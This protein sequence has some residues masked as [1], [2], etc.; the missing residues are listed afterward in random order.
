MTGEIP[1]KNGDVLIL[2]KTAGSTHLICPVSNDG[3]Q[4]GTAGYHW[5]TSK[6]EAVE[7]ARSMVVAEGRIF[8]KNQDSGEWEQISN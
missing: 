3:Q 6:S 2:T 8:L 1:T 4:A 7:K 5:A